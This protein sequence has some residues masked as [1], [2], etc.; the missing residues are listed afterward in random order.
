MG[1]LTL[2]IHCT[3]EQRDAMPLLD[4][5]R[6]SLAGRHH[7]ESPQTLREFVPADFERSAAI[8]ILAAVARERS[9]S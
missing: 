4:H 7:G 8:G 1:W 5:F 6:L 3:R 2:T 9:R